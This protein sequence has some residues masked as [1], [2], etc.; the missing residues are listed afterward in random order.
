MENVASSAS[1]ISPGLLNVYSFGW[2]LE[3]LLLE[4][5]TFQLLSVQT[6]HVTPISVQ[7]CY[8]WMPMILFQPG[9]FMERGGSPCSLLDICNPYEQSIRNG[10]GHR[11]GH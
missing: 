2:I 4:Q 8:S 5:P 7:S 10:G 9:C 6:S 3:T 11:P 1:D